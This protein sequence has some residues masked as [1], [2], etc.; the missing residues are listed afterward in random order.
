MLP[1]QSLSRCMQPASLA[2]A[3]GLAAV[4]PE[5]LF[6]LSYPTPSPWQDG[7]ILSSP[8]GAPL[9]LSE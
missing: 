9:V 5:T 3:A 4:L 7:N 2:D 6:F 1:G 8:P